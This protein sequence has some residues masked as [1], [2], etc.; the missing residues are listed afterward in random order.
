ML[1]LMLPLL[2]SLACAWF[3][4]FLVFRR[5]RLRSLRR[6]FRFRLRLATECETRQQGHIRAEEC[7]GS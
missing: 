5:R 3:L 4:L 2:L 6:I 7:H 1:S